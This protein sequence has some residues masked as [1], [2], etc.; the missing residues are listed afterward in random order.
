MK[1]FIWGEPNAAG[2]LKFYSPEL[3]HKN[4]V[5]HSKSLSAEPSL[6]HTFPINAKGKSVATWEF[7]CSNRHVIALQRI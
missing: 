5:L 6:P 4:Q 7:I 2:M 1:P 3:C